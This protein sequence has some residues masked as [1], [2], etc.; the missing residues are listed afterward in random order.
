MTFVN[1]VISPWRWAEIFIV[2]NISLLLNQFLVIFSLIYKCHKWYLLLWTCG[3]DA[4][5]N[6]LQNLCTKFPDKFTWNYSPTNFAFLDFDIHPSSGL[7]TTSVDIKPTN[8]FQYFHF[9]TFHFELTKHSLRRAC[10][11]STLWHLLKKN[12]Q[13]LYIY[14]IPNRTPPKTYP[15]SHP[16]S[17]YPNTLLNNPKHVH[18][19]LQLTFLDYKNSTLF[20]T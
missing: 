7:I 20:S 12:P 17:N 9:T 1:T 5:Y 4:P 18:P 11:C 3:Q 14:K 16:L 10:I 8:T 6:F 15:V 19:S 2:W 13:F